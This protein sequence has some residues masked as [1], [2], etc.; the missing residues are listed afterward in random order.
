[1][2]IEKTEKEKTLNQRQP[3]VALAK[4]SEMKVS[5]PMLKKLKNQF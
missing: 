5:L 4:H 3:Q 1:M 2:P